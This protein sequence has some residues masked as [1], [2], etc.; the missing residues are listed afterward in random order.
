MKEHTKTRIVFMGTPD[1]AVHILD[2]MVKEDMNI[3]GVISVPDKPAGRGKKLQMSAVKKYAKEHQLKVLTP[4]KLKDPDFLTELN[5]LKP[6]LQIVVAF[7][8][9]PEVVWS[10]PPQGTFNLHASLLPQYRGAAPINHAI[11]NGETKTG[12]STFLLDRQIDTG[13]ILMQK[14]CEIEASDSAG[15]LHDKLMELGADL[16]IQTV[17]KIEDK[18]ITPKSQDRLSKDVVLKQAPKIFKEDC[19]INWNQHSDNL[20]NFVR[21]MSPYPGAHTYLYEDGKEE[22]K[23]LK[24]FKLEK[25]KIKSEKRAGSIW[26][27]GKNEIWVATSDYDLKIIELQLQGKRRLKTAEFLRGFTITDS[28]RLIED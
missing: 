9:L 13:K 28:M 5:L 16:V 23:T 14:E 12:V 24:I 21:G 2:A 19:K 3:V 8:M 10:L 1:F 22:F 18:D 26:S 15:E 11:I 27:D 7:R 20:F 17:R 6:D 25:T 4:L